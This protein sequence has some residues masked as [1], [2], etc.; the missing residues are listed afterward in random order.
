MKPVLICPRKLCLWILVKIHVRAE[1]QW[2]SFKIVIASEGEAS[3]IL[4]FRLIYF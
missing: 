3:R 2:A 1:V 4:F